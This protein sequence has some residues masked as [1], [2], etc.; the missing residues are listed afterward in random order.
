MK[1]FLKRKKKK[2]PAYSIMTLIIGTELRGIT[3]VGYNC[4]NG[5]NEKAA[6]SPTSS[7]RCFFFFFN[8]IASLSHFPTFAIQMESVALGA[9]S[10]NA[11]G[12]LCNCNLIHD[13]IPSNAATIAV[14]LVPLLFFFCRRGFKYLITAVSRPPPTS[15]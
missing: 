5:K 13:L 9:K 14:H 11:R 2:K 12:K 7:F 1:A 10:R 3:P 6:H 4:I 15:L 8:N